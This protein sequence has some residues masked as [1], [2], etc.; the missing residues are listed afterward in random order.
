MTTKNRDVVLRDTIRRAVSTA[1]GDGMHTRDIIDVIEH[2]V[3]ALR[4]RLP[5][6]DRKRRPRRG[7]DWQRFADRITSRIAARYGE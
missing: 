1:H 2:E 3:A 7:D 4:R 5:A 6:G